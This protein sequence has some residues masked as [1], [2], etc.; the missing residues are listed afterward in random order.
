MTTAR[1]ITRAAHVAAARIAFVTAMTLSCASRGTPGV[2]ASPGGRSDVLY[3]DEIG[4]TSAQTAYDAVRML[5][6]SFLNTRGPTS[7]LRQVSQL[8]MVDLDNQRF[9]DAS[10]LRN[11]P[12]DGIVEIRYLSSTQAQM[13]WGMDHPAGAILVVT[14]TVRSTP[15]SGASN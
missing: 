2:A 11:I 15:R 1:R 12:I 6:P 14:G 5:R 3:R 9:G 8:P 10:T 4:K 13:R 7:L